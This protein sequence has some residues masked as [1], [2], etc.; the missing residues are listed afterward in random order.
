MANRFQRLFSLT[1][2]IF[3]KGCPIIIEAGALQKDTESGA[4]IA[5]IKMRNIG[6]KAIASCKLS[7]KAF[8]NN[9]DEVEGVSD[10][11][12]L[13]LNAA[14][15]AEFG[16]KVPIILPDRTTR[17][18]E[19]DIN[20][21]VFM[22]GSV[23]KM[24]NNQWEPIPEHRKIEE[25]I[26]DKLLAEQ[27]KREVGGAAELLPEKRDGFFLCTCGAVNLDSSDT[28]Y[29]CGNT[30]ES[31]VKLIDNEYLSKKLDERNKRIEAE[32][33]EKQQ[34][35]KK[36]LKI[37]I[38]AGAILL[39][40][41]IISSVLQKNSAARDEAICASVAGHTYEPDR[42]SQDFIFYSDGT[43]DDGFT[44]TTYYGVHKF[45]KD[46]YGMT[47]NFSREV[48][49][50]PRNDGDYSYIIT[51]IQGNQITEFVS[52][53]HQNGQITYRLKY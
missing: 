40:L 50:T 9:G 36:L 23:Q 49:T 37:A 11:S 13:D 51:E 48:A 33:I 46:K 26:N 1:P 39:I 25:A 4:T 47:L 2:N 31:L 41:V 29:R 44:Q 45:G 38:A 16:T 42:G 35:N 32:N 24:N 7:V 34:K 14:R 8:E 30:Y 43:V 5:Q 20:E 53:F 3:T 18:F 10:F 19:V 17:R 52:T 6:E 21:I 15:G 28:C 22:D 27:Y 12:Y